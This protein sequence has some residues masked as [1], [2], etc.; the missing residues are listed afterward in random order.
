VNFKSLVDNTSMERQRKEIGI[1]S[2]HLDP[3]MN[4]LSDWSCYRSGRSRHLL[5][6]SVRSK[7]PKSLSVEPE[8]LRVL[9]AK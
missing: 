7:G 4:G 8:Y 9:M 1:I 5:A 3:N 6:F 2:S